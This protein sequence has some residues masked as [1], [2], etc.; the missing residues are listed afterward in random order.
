[1]FQNMKREFVRAEVKFA[2]TSVVN[3]YRQRVNVQRA[4]RESNVYHQKLREVNDKAVIKNISGKLYVI[5]AG[6]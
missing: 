1:M 3:F 2:G 5:F 6:W 4:A